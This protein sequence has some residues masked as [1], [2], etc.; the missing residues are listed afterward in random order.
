MPKTFPELL[1]TSLLCIHCLGVE[2]KSI[3]FTYPS[4]PETTVIKV[5]NYIT[6]LV[7]WLRYK[8]ACAYREDSNQTAHPNSL[9]RVLVFLH[10]R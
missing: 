4:R 6:E 3:H 7:S 1:A 8:L 10:T 9:I 2:F 5:S